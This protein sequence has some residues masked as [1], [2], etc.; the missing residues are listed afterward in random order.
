VESSSTLLGTS[1]QLA[2]SPL[3]K[4]FPFFSFI[5][6]PHFDEHLANNF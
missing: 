2:G 6:N 3:N 5:K 4:G 1:M